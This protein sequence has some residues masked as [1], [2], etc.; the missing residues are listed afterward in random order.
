[1][2]NQVNYTLVH[3]VILLPKWIGVENTVH[4]TIIHDD[5]N[6]VG[7]TGIHAF[8]DYVSSHFVE[9]VIDE[10]RIQLL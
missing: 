9:A 6:T 1:M 5:K 3:I 2:K 4:I 8:G 7:T 10:L